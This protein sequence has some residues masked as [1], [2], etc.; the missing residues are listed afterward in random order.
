[1]KIVLVLILALA[2]SGCG[3]LM[4]LDR[5]V[6]TSLSAAKALGDG[7]C[8][9][10][11]RT[12]EQ[13]RAFSAALV[14]TLETAKLFSEGVEARN[15]AALPALV[16]ALTRFREALLALVPDAKET[17]DQLWRLVTRLRAEVRDATP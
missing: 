8:D 1:M 7:A 5:S 3:S 17:G 2:T 6:H 11:L 13:C 4:A 16:D 10:G 14:P 12:A 15:L 9:A